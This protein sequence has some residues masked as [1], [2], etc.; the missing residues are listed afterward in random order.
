MVT[1]HVWILLITEETFP[2]FTITAVGVFILR[3]NPPPP[4]H[5]S[6]SVSVR[7]KENSCCQSQRWSGSLEQ[8]RMG[9]EPTVKALL[10]KHRKWSFLSK[11]Q[12]TVLLTVVTLINVIVSDWLF[13]LFVPCV[14]VALEGLSRRQPRRF[15]TTWAPA[16]LDGSSS[17]R[18]RQS[19][20]CMRSSRSD[21][22]RHEGSALAAGGWP[23]R[24]EVKGHDRSK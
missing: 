5:S 2:S 6:A 19:S 1:Q 4:P 11:M 17:W 3:D 12:V 23:A 8:C 13:G 7:I 22:V 15:W 14:S 16:G 24:A 10:C 21:A 9:N 20:C 18:R